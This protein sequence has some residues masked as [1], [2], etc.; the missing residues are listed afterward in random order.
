MAIE[1]AFIVGNE[2]NNKAVAWDKDLL[3]EVVMGYCS[4]EPFLAIVEERMAAAEDELGRHLVC[5]KHPDRAWKSMN[6]AM[7]EAA[8]EHFTK[9][10]HE[11]DKEMSEI[12]DDNKAGFEKND[13]S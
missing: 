13:G 12:R 10:K 11:M 8:K 5:G 1:T 7:M 3:M 4:R 2:C 9:G 6:C